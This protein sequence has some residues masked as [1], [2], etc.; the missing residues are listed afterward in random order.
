MTKIAT[1]CLAGLVVLG[2]LKH[3]A[4]SERKQPATDSAELH[5]FLV[6]IEGPK[7]RKNFYRHYRNA[8]NQV[9]GLLLKSVQLKPSD[10]SIIAGLSQLEVIDFT[11]GNINDDDLRHLRS[12]HKLQKLTLRRTK[13][14]G[15][16]L[17][18]LQ[19]LGSLTTL[20]IADTKIS[21]ASLGH[22]KG[23]KNLRE[24]DVNDTPT[25][26]E[27]L[28]HLG[29]LKQLEVLKLGETRLTDAG[30]THLLALTR[31]RAVTLNSTRVTT[32]GL[33]QLA[34]IPGLKWIASPQATAEEWGRRMQAGDFFGARAMCSG[35]L[36]GPDK[37]EFQLRKLISFPRDEKDKKRN[38]DR[39]RYEMFWKVPDRKEDAFFAKLAVDRG[40]IAIL[41]MGIESD[42]V[43]RRP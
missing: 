40:A 6:R 10:Y 28:K 19:E 36:L 3:T 15:Q 26:N 35:G 21:N 22:L 39:F 31:L 32:A 12:L 38:R 20:S 8:D 4:A 29:Q 23:I 13:I 30:L 34:A 9:T 24:L 42:F 18:Y 5:E 1:A 14:R 16:G 25:S 27:G 37:G 41:S 2:Q 43:D 11:S 17:R 7:R 33:R